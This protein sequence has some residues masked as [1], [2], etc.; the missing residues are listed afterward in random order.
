M[1]IKSKIRTIPDYPIKGIRFRDIST[2]ISDPEGLQLAIDQFVDRYKKIDD[3]DLIVGIESRGFIVGSALSYAL[4]KGF[5]MVRKPGKL[6]GEVIAQEY[7]LEYG[8]DSLEIHVDAFNKG[9]KILLVD[10]LL[11]T[12]GTVMAAIELIQKLGGTIFEIAFI[13]DLPDL[14]GREKLIN[15]GYKIFNLTEFEGD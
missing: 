2:L 13:I 12:G 5:V 3:F 9:S 7:K 1:S 10:D 6:P 11:A 8:T 14:G 4:K 15:K